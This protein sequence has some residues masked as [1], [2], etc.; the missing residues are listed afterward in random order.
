MKG[1]LISE[2]DISPKGLHLSCRPLFTATWGCTLGLWPGILMTSKHDQGYCFFS[3][4]VGTL[5]SVG[6]SL[7]CIHVHL[8]GKC[9]EINSLKTLQCSW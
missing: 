8:R 1:G 4:A 5:H 2:M 9:G 3:C 6:R 7:G